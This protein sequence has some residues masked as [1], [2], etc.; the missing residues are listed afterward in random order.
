M[1]STSPLVA[2]SKPRRNATL[3]CA[4]CRRLK[5]RCSRVFPCT[6]CVKKGCAAICPDGS[7]TTGKGNRFVLANTEVLHEKIS[8]L[9]NRVRQL[10]DAL[11]EAHSALSH[12]RHPLLSDDLLQLKRPLEREAPEETLRDQDVETAEAIDAVGSLSITES[13]HTKFYGTTANAWYL[14]QNEAGSDDEV[15]SP[16]IPLPTDIHWLSHTFPFSSSVHETGIGIRSSIMA[17]LPEASKAR[18]LAGI[19]YQHAAWMY[20]P[21]PD[22][23]FYG[24][25]FPGIYEQRMD[26][27]PA[28]MD[29]HRLAV[30]CLVLGLGALLDLEKPSLSSEATRYYQLGRAALSLDSILEAQS[31]PA[32]QALILMCHFMFFSFVEGPLGPYGARGKASAEH[33]DSGKWNLS[34]EETF[35]RRS[36]FYELYTYDS[37][38]SLTYGRPPSFAPA[39][40]DCQ[41]A[42]ETTKLDQGDVE[43]SF[44]AWKHRFSFKCLSVVHEQAF[45]ARVPSYRSIQDL[46]K[47]VRDFYVPPSLRVPGFGGAKMETQ[48]AQCT[49]ELT[50]QRYITFAIKE[51]SL[52]YLHRGFFARAI[53]D[54]PED[55]LGSKYAP[56]VLAAYNSA[57][58]FVG[59]IKSLYSQHP[60]LTERMWFLFTHVFSCTI[61]LGSIPT[62]CPDMVLA[63]SALSHLDSAYNLFNEVSSNARAAKVLPVLRKLKDRATLSMS[64]AQARKTSAPSSARPIIDDPTVKQEDEELAALGERPASSPSEPPSHAYPPIDR[65]SMVD[66]HIHVQ[67]PLQWQGYI[68]APDVYSDYS[69]PAAVGQWQQDTSYMQ[70][71]IPM[72]M[73]P[74]QYS[75]YPSLLRDLIYPGSRPWTLICILPIQMHLGDTCSR[76]SIRFSGRLLSMDAIDPRTRHKVPLNTPTLLPKS[77]G[78]SRHL[79]A[80]LML[81]SVLHAGKYCL[82]SPDVGVFWVLVRVLACGGF[83]AMIWLVISGQLQRSRAVEW[84]VVGTSSLLL[85]LRVIIITQFS[86]VWFK[87]LVTP[88]PLPRTISILLGLAISFLSDAG[89]SPQN[90]RDIFPGYGA[91]AVEALSSSMLEH[92]EGVLL[93][94][95]GRPLTMVFSTLGACIFSLPLYMLR[96]V[97]LNST[98]SSIPSLQALAVI[99]FLSYALLYYVPRSSLAVNSLTT[100]ARDFVMSYSLTVFASIVVGYIAFGT[101]VKWTDLLVASLLL[102]GMYPRMS[103]PFVGTP[104]KPS[105]RVIRTYLKS[106][107]SNPESRKIFYFLMLNM[108]YMLVQMLYGIW[109]NSL[110]LISD[111]IHMAFDCMAIGVGLIASVM[112]R[113]PPNEKFTYGYGRIETLSG[114]ANGIFL[115]LISIFIV[116]EAI[117][118]LLDPPEMNTSQLLL[119]SSLGLGVNLFGMVVIHIHIRIRIHI[120]IVT[121]RAASLILQRRHLR[122]MVIRIAIRM[123]M[124]TNTCAIRMQYP[125]P[126]CNNA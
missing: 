115:I 33:R 109:T 16:Q 100:H 25:I 12:E 47:K 40:I 1:S 50:M 38:Q 68:Q 8:V 107:L 57:C 21:V 74:I 54:H 2:K 80:D 22:V 126:P 114:F 92:T 26:S 44:A 104:H 27:D 67:A 112:A 34:P 103:D 19:Y 18:R 122:H 51:I 56:S 23:E 98:V 94:S 86:I 63:P 102:Y 93:P 58:S 15:E 77:A 17:L 52:F 75:S 4:E 39:F 64:E 118:R 83:A 60:G 14:L 13:G 120:H 53:E 3:S 108:F 99:P 35:R 85:F 110:G 113:W 81:V 89:F 37:W 59:L 6:S 43:M 106:I 20:T 95:L 82:L 124:K 24:S 96:H 30:L 123:H 36:L 72:D 70:T 62:K 116:F 48:P 79:V 11:H 9:A 90:F 84:S 78:L 71:H 111:A 29:S 69:Y 61:A 105:T 91:L 42:E 119:V 41:M 97:L 7:L 87:C 66:S 88:A 76:N 31:I 117:Q 121:L 125:T 73:G 55:P 46:D 5:L 45:G 49:I 10:E 101:P 32:I 28:P 65:P